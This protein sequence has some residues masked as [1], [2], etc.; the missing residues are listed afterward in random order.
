MKTITFIILC[1]FIIIK[2][3]AQVSQSSTLHQEIL[4]TDT[5]FFNAYNICD[6]ET[7]AKHISDTIE[8]FHDKGGFTND[9]KGLIES[10]K[11]NIC[12]KVTRTLVPDSFEVY[13]IPDYG[14]VAMGYHT[15]YNKLEPD[16]PQKPGR[17]VMIY[18]K[19]NNV[20]QMTKALS[21]H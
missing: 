5:A 21:L 9:K 11:N 2:S 3:N 12:N 18:K 19:Q 8:F 20:W 7:Q 17:F 1:I 4:A 16:A 15:F 13:E 10:L 6:L 14:A